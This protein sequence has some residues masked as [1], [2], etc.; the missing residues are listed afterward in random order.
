MVDILLIFVRCVWLKSMDPPG[1][2]TWGEAL[3]RPIWRSFL[4]SHYRTWENSTVSKVLGGYDGLKGD[5]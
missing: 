2:S 1:W 5:G 3:G 4:E